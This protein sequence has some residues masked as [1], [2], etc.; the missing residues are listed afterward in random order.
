MLPW[1][2]HLPIS[3]CITLEALIDRGWAYFAHHAAGDD[4]PKDGH[5][6]HK[7]HALLRR[8]IAEVDGVG[9]RPQRIGHQPQIG[10]PASKSLVGAKCSRLPGNLQISDAACQTC[11][12]V[13]WLGTSL[14]V[15][16]GG[17]QQQG[18]ILDLWSSCM[19]RKPG[20]I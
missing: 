4:V 14:Q 11:K 16:D 18:V 6:I 12:N 5:A 8:H 20:K 7:E 2:P 15:G 1:I 17:G 9:C 10:Q 13:S 3:S 19:Q